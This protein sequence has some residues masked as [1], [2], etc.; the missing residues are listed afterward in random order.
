[1]IIVTCLRGV[2][3]GGTELLHQLG[4]KLNRFGYDTVICYF[5]NDDGRPA[6]HPYF[7]KYEMPVVE[8]IIDSSENIIIHPEMMAP[9]IEGF[10]K[11]YPNSTH[12]LWWL[13]VD[14]A[15]MTPELEK[16][17]SA[18][19]KLIHLV[20][21]YYAWDYVKDILSVPDDRVFYLS[22][23]INYNFL[24]IEENIYRDDT[25]L[26]NPR[27]GFE[28]TASIIKNSDFLKIKWRELAG[29]SPNDIPDVLQ[30]AKVYIDFGNHP[31]KDR[32]PREAVACGCRLITGRRGSAA[33]E[34][35]V[36]IP[37]RFKVSDDTDDATILEQI[38]GLID[39]YD[40][41]GEYYRDYLNK[42]KEEFHE[43]EIDTLKVFSKLTDRKIKG[44]N[45]DE[46]ELK[47]RI[48]KAVTEEEYKDALYYITV[49]RMKGFEIEDDILILEG[50]TRL[51]LREEQVAMYLM[52]L[53]LERDSKNYEAYLIMA[54]SMFALKNKKA[55]EMLNNAI[56]YSIG[57][58]DEDYIKGA[59]ELLRIGNK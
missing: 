19:E 18:D 27:K 16:S 44:I 50:Y 37:D 45:L 2:A 31:G 13:S 9:S 33:N 34:F 24:N 28:R 1:M 51:G 52:G 5:G 14:N 41:T 32:F 49:Y 47:N 36:P 30:S 25:V 42:I 53:L 55:E 22:D 38:Y 46:L 35:D 21:S 56:K 57:T 3:T 39:D 20:Q 59:V 43:F 29:I 26:F 54:R 7:S 11:Q 8:E 17:I 15:K 48:I 12:V 10:M 6:M 40:L 4:Y 23:Y 58:E